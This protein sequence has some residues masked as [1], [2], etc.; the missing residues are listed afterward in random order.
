MD[1]DMA[2]DGG[3]HGLLLAGA[4]V[5]VFGLGLG[6]WCALRHIDDDSTE[7]SESTGSGGSRGGVSRRRCLR[8]LVAVYTWRRFPFRGDMR[9]VTACDCLRLPA[10]ERACKGVFRP[11]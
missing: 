5:H 4:A 10:H 6:F 9:L 7:S 11:R 8:G 3:R 2:G 1:A